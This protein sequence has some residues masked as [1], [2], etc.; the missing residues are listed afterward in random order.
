[1]HQAYKELKAKVQV[2]LEQEVE[3][4]LDLQQVQVQELLMEEL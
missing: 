2:L 1:L 3:Q 4:L